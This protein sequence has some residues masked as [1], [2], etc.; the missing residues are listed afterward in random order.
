[1]KNILNKMPFLLQEEKAYTVAPYSN[2]MDRRRYMRE[3]DYNELI[4]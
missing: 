3:T 4:F 1:M 2:A